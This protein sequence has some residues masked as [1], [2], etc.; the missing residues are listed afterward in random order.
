MPLSFVIGRYF[1]YSF[2]A[3]AAAW[4]VSFAALF[5]A[6]RIGWVYEA[7][8]GPANVRDVAE[9]L[10]DSGINEPADVP[11][12]Y[13][14]L[15]MGDDGETLMTDLGG[16]RFDRAEGAA[17]AALG[18]EP[19]AVRVEGGGSG[20]T[21][22]AFPIS[23]GGSCALVSDFL[24]QWVSRGVAEAAPNPQGLMLA[25]AVLGSALALALTARRASSVIARKMAPLTEAA[26]RVGAGELDFAVGRTNVREVNDVLGA[27]D[28]M[29]SSLSD[30]L[31][32]RWAVERSQREQV[33]SLA[34]D[35]K[36]PLTV[37][38]ANAEFIAEE[39]G[40]EDGDLAAAARDIAGGA[41][42]LDG[43]VRLLI[44]ASRGSAG[45][46]RSPRGQR[47]CA[48]GS[49]RRP[50]RSLGRAGCASTPG[51]TR[52]SRERTR[53]AWTWTPC[54]APQGTSCSTPPSTR[55]RRLPS[56]AVSRTASWSWRCPTTARAFPRPHSSAVASACSRT[57][58]LAA[59]PVE[60]AITGSGSTPHPSRPAPTV[61]SSPSRTP[62]REG[63]WRR[64]G[65]P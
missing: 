22:A 36:T 10:A 28:E 23:G 21:Y 1:A 52:L 14:Y 49:S 42:R 16:A 41:E 13:G 48:G 45:P 6:I 7:S 33:A 29:R 57:T 20:L 47:I 17:L 64:C 55:C 60:G 53:R 4:L 63:R 2:A 51:S 62:R 61:D 37:M 5:A 35:L 32:A 26:G 11:T 58:P 31:E 54:P 8:W 65:S 30:S 34:H 56:A 9:R 18:A 25:S 15:V 39:L 59:R 12:A 27:M 38:R 24:P 19:G 44:E 40:E 50:A 43:Y 3:V 46:G